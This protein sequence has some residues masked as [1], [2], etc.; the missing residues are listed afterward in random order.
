[1]GEK[2]VEVLPPR[3]RGGQ[4]CGK[5]RVNRREAMDVHSVSTPRCSL[6]ERH[7]RVFLRAEFAWRKVED[8]GDRQRAR[9]PDSNAGLDLRARSAARIP[10]LR[11]ML[12]ARW[13]ATLSLV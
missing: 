6:H 11:C 12:P 10:V 5:D 13:I 9:H 4:S 8:G 3:S 2:S 7:D 1:M